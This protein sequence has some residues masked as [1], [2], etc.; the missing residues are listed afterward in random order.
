[1]QGICW[2]RT[3]SPVV[4]DGFLAS[5]V[6][7]HIQGHKGSR[8]IRMLCEICVKPSLNAC[9]FRHP[10]VLSFQQTCK[11]SS[12]MPVALD[13]SIFFHSKKKSRATFIAPSLD[14]SPTK[15]YVFSPLS[16]I[17]L[18]IR[19]MASWKKTLS[20]FLSSH[21]H[22]FPRSRYV[23]SQAPLKST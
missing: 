12:I 22:L 6:T 10:R 17:S 2:A 23:M 4:R 9:S 18:F 7:P 5:I 19:S 8:C 20:S 15:I 16:D 3:R 11:H 14:I 1:M 13:T 21:H